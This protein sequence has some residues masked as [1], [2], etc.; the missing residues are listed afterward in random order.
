MRINILFL[1]C[2]FCVLKFYAQ[3]SDRLVNITNESINTEYADFGV[4]FYKDN[5][6]L[7]ASSRIDES[8]K[9]NGRSNNRQL[10]LKFYK[11]VIGNEGEIIFD[12]VFSSEKFN[13][14]YESDITFMPNDKTIFFTLNNYIDDEYASNFKK[15]KSKKQIL[16]IYKA[17]IDDSGITTNIE[18]VPFNNPNYSVQDPQLSP[19]G[20]TLFFV[21]DD[22]EGFGQSDIY[23]VAINDDGTYGQPIN[24]GPKVNSEGLEGFP[25]LSTNNILY[26]SSNG[27]GGEGFMDVFSSEF[28]GV[29]YSNPENL[30]N[31]INSQ[32]D[33]FA[34]VVSPEKKV[35]YF[36]S[37][38]RGVGGV[39][40]YSFI[41][42][43]EEC[44]QL[45]AGILKNSLDDSIIT[46]AKVEL[47]S[48]NELIKT[49]DT[50]QDGIYAFTLSC[51]SDYKLIVTREGHSAIDINITTSSIDGFQ[52]DLPLFI[53]PI[54]CIQLIT[55]TVIKQK[56]ASPL[57]N[58]EL[59]LY[60]KNTLVERTFS[61]NDGSF[62]F[63]SELECSTSYSITAQGGIYS[64]ITRNIVT[65][66]NSG[67]NS[68]VKIAMKEFEDFVTVRNTLMIN[69][70]PIQFDLNESIIEKDV[71]IEL[72][73]VVAIMK[74]NPTI[75]VEVNSH[76]DSRAPDAYN[77]RLSR[78]RA[79]SIV[80]YIESKGIDSI[81]ISGIGYGET[82]LI[83][84]CAN[85]VD[86]TETEHQ[87]NR[88]TEFV[89]IQ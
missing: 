77:M 4:T 10:N 70:N 47:Y 29:D 85:G 41:I 71:A 24:L 65:S 69:S 25:F 56:D 43:E 66:D 8:V 49:I 45:I 60:S 16:A 46:N 14:F 36:S 12:G 81:R 76:T 33:D 87:K 13:I 9:R 73:K 34:F 5:K 21:S 38:R 78:D 83:N 61:Q 79:V 68:S 63:S 20:K 23:K 3:E 48:N 67:E 15:S 19:D 22:P 32:Y 37:T 52:D 54:D 80:S 88:R 30:G 86:C 11:G 31:T 17:N 42:E 18:P 28:N 53:A 44:N 26:F 72:N 2:T 35:G 27:H 51:N 82:E 55:G 74:R 1:L 6:I 7:F 62:N 59:A 39:D 89:V 64:P 50:D 75:K 84:K 57:F 40:I 58:I